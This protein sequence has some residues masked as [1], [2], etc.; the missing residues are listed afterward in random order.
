[1]MGDPS[2]AGDVFVNKEY[3]AIANTEAESRQLTADWTV[4]AISHDR[5]V[6]EKKRRGIYAEDTDAQDERDKVDAE[7]TTETE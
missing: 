1:M 4:G 7:G 3:A 5:L 6:A 2:A